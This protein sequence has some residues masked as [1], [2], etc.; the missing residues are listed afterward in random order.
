M[1]QKIDTPLNMKYIILVNKCAFEICWT[2]LN[3]IIVHNFVTTIYQKCSVHFNDLFFLSLNFSLLCILNDIKKLS[4]CNSIA[5][6][7]TSFSIRRFISRRW[8]TEIIHYNAYRNIL[9]AHY[10][11]WLKKLII[12]FFL[13]EITSGHMKMKLARK[14]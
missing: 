11:F 12:K 1:I 4:E 3:V 13:L 6:L 7:K 9:A 8:W 14:N 5:I 10:F 2:C